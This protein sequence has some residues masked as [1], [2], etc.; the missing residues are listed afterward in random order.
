MPQTEARPDPSLKAAA[1]SGRLILGTQVLRLVVRVG[2]TVALARLVGPTDYGIFGMAGTVYGLVYVFQDFGL[3]TVTLRKQHLT[4]D[5]R[6]ALFWLNL[7]LGTGLTVAVAA[8]SFAV[9]A[10]FHEATLRILLPFMGTTFFINGLHTQ[11]RAQLARD[12]RFGDLNRVDIGAFTLS[13][14]AAIGVAWLGGGAWALATMAVVA[15]VATAVGIWRTQRWRPGPWP[16]DFKARALLSSGA[17]LSAND[18]LRYAQRNTDLFLVGKWLGAGPLGIYGRAAQFASLPVIYLVDP[19]ASLAIST[20]RHLVPLPA[21]ARIF[22]RRI[23]NALAWITMPAA[24]VFASM[25]VE[26]L[27][28]L[29]GGRWTPGAAVLRGLAPGLAMLPLQMASAWMFLAT[30]TRRRLLASSGLNAALVVVACF[31]LRN[32]GISAIATGVG[33]ASAAGAL[34]SPAFMIAADPVKPLDA[35][36]ALARPLGGAVALGAALFGVVHLCGAL[37]PVPRLCAGIAVGCAWAGVLWLAWPQART[38][39]REHLLLRGR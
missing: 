22:W 27:G 18:G 26:L 5:D 30:G 14:M 33:L 35:V 36:S 8:A 4:G 23:V 28:V 37:G 39:W 31:L 19:L 3:A 9:A 12:H 32:S 34:T 2:G 21:E 6:N 29:L 38:E 17:S 16:A 24:A 1:R 10:F 7:V 15:E 11:L 13:T 20:L 25:P